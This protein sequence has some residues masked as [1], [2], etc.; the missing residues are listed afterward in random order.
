MAIIFH[1]KTR[2][3]EDHFLE[4]CFQFRSKYLDIVQSA[5]HDWIIY[6]QPMPRAG[7]LAPRASGY[8]AA[9][10]IHDVRISTRE[11]YYEALLEQFIAFPTTVPFA[12][13]DPYS[14]IVQYF[15][16]NMQETDGS[17]NASLAQQSVRNVSD[18][19]F[20][21]IINVGLRNADFDGNL[22]P[23]PSHLWG[24]AAPAPA[25][26][27]RTRVLASRSMRKRAFS[28]VVGP[29]YR[30]QCAVTG[31]SLWAPDGSSE[32]EC[33]HIMPIE[34]GGP[35][36]VRNGLA[37]SR[38]IH[39]MFDKGLISISTDGRILRSRYCPYEKPDALINKSGRVRVPD[40]SAHHPHP[41]FL[42]YHRENVFLGGLP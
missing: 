3:N 23:T 5:L 13:R 26:L 28:Q 37:L 38:T 11:G 10:R 1:V 4:F 34:A 36:S 21:R 18:F 33:A 7:K 6:Y 39:W 20:E 25:S 2:E 27:N 29:A 41:E 9:A 22:A 16:A 30:M 24:F 42:R 12:T 8:F 35:D 17:V 19:D 14:N 40:D 31:I 15:E 32:V